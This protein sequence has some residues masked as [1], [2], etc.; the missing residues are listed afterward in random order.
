MFEGV[1]EVNGIRL[2][3][4]SVVPDVVSGRR[5]H[6]RQVLNNLLDNAI[7]FTAQ[8][9]D[10]APRLDGGESGATAGEPEVSVELVRDDEQEIARLTVRDNGVGI[11]AADLP[12][13]FDRFY[14]AD[15]SRGRD[16]LASGTGLGLSIC[17]AIVEAHHGTIQVASEPGRGTTV[18]MTLPLSM[19]NDCPADPCQAVRPL[20]RH[21][22]VNSAPTQHSAPPA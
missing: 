21:I 4:A 20:S 19:A 8:K 9:Y 6:L 7:K 5:Y 1:A 10:V 17:Q 18:T 13:V 22:F 16:G 11:P 15:R 14:R 3:S 2:R 12:N